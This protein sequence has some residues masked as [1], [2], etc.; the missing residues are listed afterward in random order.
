MTNEKVTEN[1]I[2]LPLEGWQ[3]RQCEGCYFADDGK[4]GTGQP[5]CTYPGYLVCDGLGHCKKRREK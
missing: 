4:V 5:C 1:Y 2:A 3:K